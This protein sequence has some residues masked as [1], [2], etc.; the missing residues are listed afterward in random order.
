VPEAQQLLVSR[1]H[2]LTQ[3]WSQSAVI[4]PGF[5]ANADMAGRVAKE[6]IDGVLN[7]DAFVILTSNPKSGTGRY[8]ELGAGLRPELGL[9]DH[10]HPPAPSAR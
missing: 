1:G 7:A 2:T 3:D 4:P 5:A 8:V 6:D 9:L 10:D